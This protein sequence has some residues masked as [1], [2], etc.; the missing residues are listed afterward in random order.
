MADDKIVTKKTAAKP[1]APTKKAPAKAA[2]PAKTL[3]KKAV[4][5]P[6]PA[7]SAMPPMAKAAA[8]AVAARPAAPAKASVPP[9]ATTGEPPLADP[10]VRPSPLEEKPVSF[11]G[12]AEVTAEERLAMIR[13]AAYYKAE[14]R[15]FAAGN[16]AEDWSDAE[17]EID[18][19]LA[20]AREIYGR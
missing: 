10:D 18:E 9:E 7:A 15:G 16:D 4:T 19:L 3:A 11:R 8:T 14:K 20:K 6:A 17:R 2:A 12:L 5:K 13:E 1:A